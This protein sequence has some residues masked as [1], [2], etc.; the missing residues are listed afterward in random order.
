MLKCLECGKEYKT[1]NSLSRHISKHM[2]QEE[3]Y[4]KYLKKSDQEGKCVIYGKPTKYDKFQ[5][6]KCCSQSCRNTWI[7]QNRTEEEKQQL[8]KKISQAHLSESTK[9]KTKETNLKKY[10]VPYVTQNLD[11][12]EKRK[13][14]CQ[15]K[16]GTDYS[17]QAESVKEKIQKS[18]HEHYG[19]KGLKAKEIREKT[20]ATCQERYG[21]NNGGCSK[22]ALEK[23]KKTT[24]KHYGVECSWQSEEVKEKIKQNRIKLFNQ[25]CIDN[26]CTPMQE[27]IDLY[28]TGWY[29]NGNVVKLV[30]YNKNNYCVKNEDIDKIRA[31]YIKMQNFHNSIQQEKLFDFIKSFY[32]DNIEVNKK[33]YIF[34]YELDIILPKLNLAIEYNGTYWH[35]AEHGINKDYHLIK[36]LMCREKEIRL[37]HIYEF[38]NIV[39]Q[40]S[41]L[42]DLILG[43]DNYPKED[44]NKNNLIDNI[45]DA[46]IIYNDKYTVYGAGKLY[47]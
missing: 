47:I 43:K 10:G 14:T 20:I 11:I 32:N 6:A 3:Y 19:E 28:G 37:I 2:P 15:E 21:T 18:I 27:L 46:E 4:I 44:F 41:L 17:F 23:I 29:Q 31:Y 24:L 7:N 16:Y 45:P 36:S 40:Y 12:Q 5:Y 34:P 25:F 8:H 38:E 26:N 1:L 42:K 22:E 30:I 39:E 33:S 13:Q 35:S 9:N